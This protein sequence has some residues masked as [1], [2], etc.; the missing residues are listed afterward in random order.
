MAPQKRT[1]QPKTDQDSHL[2]Q[3]GED[4]TTAFD[5]GRIVVPLVEESLN[6]KKNWVQAGEVVF[7]KTVRPIPKKSPS[8]LATKRFRSSGY[9]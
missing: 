3:T 5:D 8:N 7:R 2:E 6:V 9:P 4:L 1:R